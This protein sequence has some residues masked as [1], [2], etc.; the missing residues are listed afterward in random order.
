MKHG[1]EDGMLAKIEARIAALNAAIAEAASLGPQYRIGHSFLTPNLD[2][3]IDDAR[4]WF[5]DKVETEIGP[6]LDEYWYDAPDMAQN[7]RKKLLA[8]FT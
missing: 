2:E 7:E 3:M 8:H 4:A 1:L 5:Q 6:L